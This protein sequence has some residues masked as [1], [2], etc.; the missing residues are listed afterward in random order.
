MVQVKRMRKW[1]LEPLAYSSGTPYS[2][3]NQVVEKTTAI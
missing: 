2:Q 1:V 3:L